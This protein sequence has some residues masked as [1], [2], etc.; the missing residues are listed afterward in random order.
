MEMLPPST[1][2]LLLEIP[3]AQW[4]KSPKTD[5]A[6]RCPAQAMALLAEALALFRQLGDQRGSRDATAHGAGHSR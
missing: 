4:G 2:I 3:Y 1:P 6:D 5:W